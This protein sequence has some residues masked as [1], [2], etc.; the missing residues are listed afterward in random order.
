MFFQ[1]FLLENMP[2]DEWDYPDVEVKMCD[3][4]NNTVSSSDMIIYFDRLL[5][6]NKKKEWEA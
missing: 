1:D 3:D 5:R 4:Y 2:V 6:M